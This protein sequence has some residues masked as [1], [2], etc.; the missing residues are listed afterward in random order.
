MSSAGSRA[1]DMALELGKVLSET[2][3]FKEMKR[4][5]ELLFSD[6]EALKLIDEVKNLHQEYARKQMS[7]QPITEENIRVLREA[8]TAAMANPRVKAS[9]EANRR[10]QKL[11]EQITDKIKEG[12]KANWYKS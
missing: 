7:G 8:E 5:E 4:A 12:A 9:F 1:I 11:V 6:E 10:F 3:E 2:D